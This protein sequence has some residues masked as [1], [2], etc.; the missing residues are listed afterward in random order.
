MPVIV[1]LDSSHA[2]EAAR[3][4]IAGQPGT[5][6]TSLGP[7]VLTVLYR[8]LPQTQAGFGF[9]AIENSTTVET[10][11][12]MAGFV[13]ATTSVGG[14]FLQLG[15]RHITRFLPSLAAR[16]ARQPFLA[17]RS[18]QTLLYP[19][20]VGDSGSDSDSDSESGGQEQVVELL[21]IMVQPALRGQGIGALLLKALTD[22]CLER[23]I[24]LLDV[25][26]DANNDGA[27]RFYERHQFTVY[28]SFMLYG[29]EMCQYRRTI[30][31][32]ARG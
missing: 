20:M 31:E 7:D 3:L 12:E 29:R 21:S 28:K 24:G 15:T 17:V 25:T 1:P 18:V 6:L 10:S 16:Y 27:R 23:R 22:A 5:F 32:A 30:E 4:H 9:A 13:S 11:P 14:L 19:L 2:A 8:V 26:V